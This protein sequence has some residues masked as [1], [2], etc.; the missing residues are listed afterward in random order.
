MLGSR[1]VVRPGS[2]LRMTWIY[3]SN[4]ARV[5]PGKK[6]LMTTKYNTRM[7]IC[8]D[9]GGIKDKRSVRCQECARL[10]LHNVSASDEYF[11]SQV[12]VRSLNEC[13]VWKGACTKDG[14]GI[15]YNDSAHRRALAI[16]LGRPLQPG[17]C[18]L[19]HCDNPPCCNPAHLFLGTNLDNIADKVTKGRSPTGDQNGSRL[20]PDRLHRGE[21]VHTARLTSDDVRE[22]RRALTEG[23]GQPILAERYGVKQPTISDIKVG[24]TWKHV[25]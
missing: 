3:L 4:Q 25:F 21:Q 2:F 19:H 1:H 16:K 17:E 18:S 15:A 10:Y 8:P 22:I 24:K 11:W 6:R 7:S 9:C 23:V 14:Y 12:D 20:Y 5:D 13:W